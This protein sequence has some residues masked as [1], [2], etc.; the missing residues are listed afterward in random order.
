MIGEKCEGDDFEDDDRHKKEKPTHTNNS[1]N[2]KIDNT[3]SFGQMI[4]YLITLAVV[5][6]TWFAG[7]VIAKGF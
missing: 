1:T 3:P 7:I 6:S 5:L 2:I 4:G